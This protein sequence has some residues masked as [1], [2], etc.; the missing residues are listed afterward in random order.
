MIDAMG[1]ASH[2]KCT[3]ITSPEEV[4]KRAYYCVESGGGT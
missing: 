1:G 2:L 3:S 4:L